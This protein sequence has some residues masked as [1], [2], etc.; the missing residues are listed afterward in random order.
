MFA[1]GRRRSPQPRFVRLTDTKIRTAKPKDRP[2]K[3]GD[4]GWLF[5]LVNP[6][7]SKL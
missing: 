6:S 2:Y 4:G 1:P 3:L 7:G 5:L